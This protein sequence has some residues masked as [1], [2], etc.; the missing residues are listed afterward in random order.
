M[1]TTCCAQERPQEPAQESPQESEIEQPP[2]VEAG[3][4]LVAES[5][6]EAAGDVKIPEEPLSEDPAAE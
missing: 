3:P 1:V 6:G 4:I 5:P 2:A